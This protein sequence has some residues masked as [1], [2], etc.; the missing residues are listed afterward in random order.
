MVDRS[1][2]R[3]VS[4][5][6]LAALAALAPVLAQDLGPRVSMGPG[7]DPDVAVDSTGRL[8]LV[9]ERGGSTYYRTLDYPETVGDEVL[10]G[11]GGDPQVALDSRDEP[12]VAMGA[13]E[14]ARWNG[15]GFTAPLHLMDAWRKPRLAIDSQDRVHVTVSRLDAPRVVLLVLA[16]GVVIAGPDPVGDDNNGA[17]DVDGADTAQLTWRA[18]SVYHNTYTV[19]GGA[20]G[21]TELHRSSDFSW[22][23][24]DLRDDSLH[25]VNTVAWGEGIHYRYR[26]GG[27]WSDRQTV[28]LD[29][30]TGVDDP[31]NVGPTIDVDRDGIKYVAFAGRGRVPYWFR[32]DTAGRPSGVFLLDPDGGSLSGGKYRNPNVGAH[33]GRA[34][35]YVAWGSGTVYVRSLPAGAGGPPATDPPPAPARLRIRN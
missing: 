14:Y 11:A 29:E 26:A 19:G 13:L 30:V 8:H 2:L 25:V 1:A 7:N 5:A 35:A 31:D 15:A 18:S 17:V 33:P 23:A 22:I 20:G 28:A 9:Y 21:S 4:L 16:N 3:L 27:A 34:G 32:V 12:H 24:V 6:A 10:I